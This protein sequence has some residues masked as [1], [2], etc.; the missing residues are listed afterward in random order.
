MTWSPRRPVRGSTSSSLTYSLHTR[1]MGNND[2]NN[3][4]NNGYNNNKN[5]NNKNNNNKNKSII[6]RATTRK[7]QKLN[8]ESIS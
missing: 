6:I 3:N 8:L 7:Q 4:N 2:N 5:N 1:N